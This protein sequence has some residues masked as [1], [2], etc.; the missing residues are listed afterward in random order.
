M[1]ARVAK[2]VPASSKVF[3]GAS[4]SLLVVLQADEAKFPGQDQGEPVGM[5]QSP[6]VL[7]VLE[8]VIRFAPRT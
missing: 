4:A 7:T 2:L 1:V 5:T 6:E 8:I 3:L